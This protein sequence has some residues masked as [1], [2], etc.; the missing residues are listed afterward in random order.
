MR[1]HNSAVKAAMVAGY[2][3]HAVHGFD[4]SFRVSKA[5][6]PAPASRVEC[7]RKEVTAGWGSKAGIH[8]LLSHPIVA[9]TLCKTTLPEQLMNCFAVIYHC[10]STHNNICK[11]KRQ[12]PSALE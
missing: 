1:Y 11:C 12:K 6:R 10:C 4:V 9:V 2:G 8:V 3:S 7:C 5:L